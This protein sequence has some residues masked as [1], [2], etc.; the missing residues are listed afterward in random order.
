MTKLKE[1]TSLFHL[2][3][4]SYQQITYIIN[5]MKSSGL[6][7]PLDETLITCFKR[8]PYLRIFMLGICTEVFRS[9]VDPQYNE[10]GDEMENSSL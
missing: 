10:P 6:S 1:H 2:P 9:T 3:S 5:C 4:P 8:R 7:Y